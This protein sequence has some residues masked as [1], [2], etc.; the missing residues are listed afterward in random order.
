MDV[1][2]RTVA[3]YGRFSPRVR[4]RFKRAIEAR[5]GHVLRDLTRRGDLLVVGANASAL[6]DSGALPARLGAARSRGIPVFGEQA[7]SNALAG[8][9]RTDAATLPLSTAL[10]QTGLTP[11]DADILAAFDLVV[12]EGAACRFADAGVIRQAAELVGRGLTRGQTVRTLQSAR[13]L[14][15]KGRHRITVTPSGEAALEWEGGGLTTLGGQALLPLEEDHPSLDDLFDLAAIAEAE[16]DLDEAARLYDQCAR[17][18]RGDAI[19]PYNLANIHLAQGGHDEAVL[20]YR[21]ALAR[22]PDL[23]EAR[24]NLARALELMDRSDEARAELGRAL[25]ADPTYADAVFNLAGLTMKA[26]E[27]GAAKS[28]YERFLTLDPPADWAATARKAITYCS[29]QLSA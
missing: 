1:G 3:L 15:P 16:G 14:A 27:I 9:D 21:R 24:Y 6:I 13:D 8:K 19:A 22:D 2:G 10:A 4:E 11:D 17:A 12:V 29:A 5:A 20:G 28:L 26:G 7:F 23:T 18:D 25:D